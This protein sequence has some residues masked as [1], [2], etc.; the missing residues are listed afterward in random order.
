ML[1]PLKIVSLLLLIPAFAGIAVAAFARS[2][3][4]QKSDQVYIRRDR[5]KGVQSIIL[6]PN[7]TLLYGHVGRFGTSRRHVA[8]AYKIKGKTILLYEMSNHEFQH[9]TEMSYT[10]NA[11]NSVGNGVF[12]RKR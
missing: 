5:T 4:L 9:V 1:K 6:R 7:G 12:Y 3:P 11:I 8:G 2:R 10:P